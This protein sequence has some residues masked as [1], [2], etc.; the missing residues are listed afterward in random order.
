MTLIK[1]AMIL[2]GYQALCHLCIT[3]L[4]LP[5]LDTGLSFQ[6]I[7]TED[8][9][10][11]FAVLDDNNLGPTPNEF[12]ICSSV[13]TGVWITEM[14]PFQLLHDNGQSWISFRF[15][16]PSKNSRNHQVN[17]KVRKNP[18]LLNISIF[19]GV[20]DRLNSQL[21]FDSGSI[22]RKL[23]TCLPGNQLH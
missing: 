8:K 17:I 15:W 16:P 10:K 21:C 12:T 18:Y 20:W 7:G 1:P 6:S 5:A 9:V 11:D 13:S 19:A 14:Y 23:V 4:A 22:A 3:S 2:V